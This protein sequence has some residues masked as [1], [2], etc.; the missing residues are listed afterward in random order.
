MTAGQRVALLPITTG[1]PHLLFTRRRGAAAAQR[2][3]GLLLRRRDPVCVAGDEPLV[4]LLNDGCE[5]HQRFLR[6]T[7]KVFTKRL[8]TVNEA[9]SVVGVS[10][11]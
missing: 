11:A 4:I 6:S 7:R 10:C 1:T 5:L 9:D 8:M 2:A 3:D